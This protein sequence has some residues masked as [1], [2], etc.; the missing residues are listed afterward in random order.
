MDFVPI[1]QDLM[2]YIVWDKG[3]KWIEVVFWAW[4][5]FKCFHPTSSA[6]GQET[7]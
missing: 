1:M 4:E 5:R 2:N 6:L 3:I 7:Y